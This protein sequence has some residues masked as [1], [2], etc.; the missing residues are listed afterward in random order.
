MKKVLSL[1]VAITSLTLVFVD[2]NDNGVK[3]PVDPNGSVNV[4]ADTSKG[5]SSS[6]SLAGTSWKLFDVIGDDR[7]WWAVS[8]R[9]SNYGDKLY[10]LEF[11]DDSTFIT[12]S[13]VNEFYGTYTMNF[14][15]DDVFYSIN[16]SSGTKVGGPPD[17]W[18]D[19]HLLV[20][21]FTV[22]ENELK[23]FY[24]DGENCLLFKPLAVAD[25]QENRLIYPTEVPNAAEKAKE[26]LQKSMAYMSVD[27]VTINLEKVN[28]QG[29]FTLQFGERAIRV[30]KEQVYYRSSNSYTFVGRNS[31]GE[32]IL[33]SVLGND[34][35]GVIETMNGHFSIMTV[36][37]N[38]Y[39][40][41]LVDQS[42]LKDEPDDWPF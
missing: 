26:I 31:Y 12:Y 16:F 39:A 18:W 9:P 11:K 10:T 29:Q 41:V 33:F 40:V 28:N 15:G 38:E 14:S 23:L 21:T 36:G 13:W 37:E 6:Q 19:T 5:G 27:F 34:I 25:G 22:Q 8:D 4:P 3:P 2:C 1:L 42:K 17:L 32:S 7:D 35:Q 30:N 20:E 24:N